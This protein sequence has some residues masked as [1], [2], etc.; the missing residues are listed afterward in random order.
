[1]LPLR[2]TLLLAGLA[3]AA[4]DA[5]PD[6][7]P[8]PPP[9]PVLVTVLNR[10]LGRGADLGQAFAGDAATDVEAAALY[11]ATIATDYRERAGRLAQEIRLRDPD[12]VTLQEV[13]TTRTQFPSDAD[14]VPATPNAGRVTF[15][16]LATLLD[17]LSAAGADYR[18]AAEAQTGDVE[19]A[20]L[21][22][23]GE[24]YDVRYT[25]RAV[26]LVRDTLDTVPGPAVT[27]PGA[28]LAGAPA[29]REPVGAAIVRLVL[30]AQT[31]AVASAR[32]DA[33]GERA[34]ALALDLRDAVGGLP[35]VLGGSTTESGSAATLDAVSATGLEDAWLGAGDGAGGTCCIGPDLRETD[36]VF[37][38]R[39]DAVWTWNGN[40]AA[41]TRFA[42]TPGIRSA[43]GLWPS[44]R[45]GLFAR[46]VLGVGTGA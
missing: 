24:R 38:R 39:T 7:D 4:C 31:V 41:I 6:P 25:E 32:F 11:Q 42:V 5:A 20:A 44:S 34:A 35:L 16:Y 43:S 33:D 9:D 2:P 45:A 30:T 10:T 37:D 12:V 29:L 21:G 28:A 17:S 15:D 23:G 46:V 19:L 14:G 27:A 18:V 36:V 13:L 8:P 40:A 22:V 1:M 3:L 26:V